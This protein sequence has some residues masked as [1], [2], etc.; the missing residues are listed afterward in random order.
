MARDRRL[1]ASEAARRRS[2]RRLRLAEHFGGAA[3][4]SV[5]HERIGRYGTLQGMELGGG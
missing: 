4:T 2:L 1:P 3:M 5:S